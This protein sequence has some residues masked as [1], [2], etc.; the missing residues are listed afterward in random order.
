MI[1]SLLKFLTAGKSLVGE[2]S[3]VGRYQLLNPRAMPKFESAKNP[4]R[5]SI[6]SNTPEALGRSSEPDPVPAAKNGTPEPLA[7]PSAHA[8]EPVRGSKTSWWTGK[9]S[10]AATWFLPRRR[11]VEAQTQ[12][13]NIAQQRS[14]NPGGLFPWRRSNATRS[15]GPRPGKS[16]VQSEL[17]L[18]TVKVVRNDL[19]DSDLEIV[20]SNKV[21][22]PIAE[23]ARPRTSAQTIPTVPGSAQPEGIA[24]VKP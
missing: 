13:S 1:M 15:V 20:A 6:R 9:F 16:M 2:R 24:V 7:P 4:F 11:A 23:K 14:S 18:E 8:P 10:A 3:L 21:A 22:A 19:T 12:P 5:S 17:S